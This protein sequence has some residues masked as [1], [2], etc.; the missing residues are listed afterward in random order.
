MKLFTSDLHQ[1]ICKLWNDK[2]IK[3]VFRYRYEFHL[4]DGAEH[5]LDNLEKL[6]PSKYVPDNVDILNCRRKTLGILSYKYNYND[7]V[8]EFIDVGGQRNERKKWDN[9]FEGLSAL[10]FVTSISDYDQLCYE[11]NET[12]RLTE[13]L[14]TFQNIVTNEKLQNIPI[15]L[16]FNKIDVFKEKIKYFEL[17][18][19]FSEYDGGSDYGK[20]IKYIEKEFKQSNKNNNMLLQFQSCATSMDSIYEIFFGIVDNFD[21]LNQKDS[22]VKKKNC[23]IC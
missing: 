13:S 11:D 2:A 16:L 4:F 15:I 22:K 17:N 19:L 7:Y 3:E 14:V 20:A 5:F 18:R 21:S 23:I 12:N 8:F 9:L 6:D 1:K 10:L